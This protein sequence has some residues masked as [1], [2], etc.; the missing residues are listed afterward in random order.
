MSIHDGIMWY[1]NGLN[2]GHLMK[3]VSNT[4]IQLPKIPGDEDE[5]LLSDQRLQKG[6]THPCSFSYP[7]VNIS[8][9][10][11]HRERNSQP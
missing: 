2:I 10:E 1:K 5:S 3:M 4:Y 9:Q 7:R 8:V 11:H 6:S